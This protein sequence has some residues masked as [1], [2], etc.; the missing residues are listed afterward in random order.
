MPAAKTE[1]KKKCNNKRKILKNK[2]KTVKSR[3]R[4]NTLVD[5][6]LTVVQICGENR[7]EFG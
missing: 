2:T 4:L 7:I 5:I 1:A 6:W 3:R